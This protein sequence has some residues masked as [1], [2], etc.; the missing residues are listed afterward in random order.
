MLGNFNRP[1]L[2]PDGGTPEKGKGDRVL[3]DA[4]RAARMAVAKEFT[5]DNVTLKPAIEPSN[6]G[7]VLVM[8]LRS[9]LNITPILYELLSKLFTATTVAEFTTQLQKEEQSMVESFMNWLRSLSWQIGTNTFTL[10]QVSDPLTASSIIRVFKN[11]KHD[12]QCSTFELFQELKK[13]AVKT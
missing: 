9:S 4:I 7:Y 12:H 11:A 3:L 8:A 10:N 2:A 5:G 1:L 6:N 13:V